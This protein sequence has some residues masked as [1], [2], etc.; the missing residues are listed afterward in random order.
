M[1][2]FQQSIVDSAMDQSE[3]LTAWECDFIGDMAD[4][5]DDYELSEKQ[6]KII[7]RIAQKLE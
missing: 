4:K 1:N 2:G 5:P 6:N 7:N 3:K